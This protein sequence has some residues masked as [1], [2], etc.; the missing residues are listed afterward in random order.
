M[1]ISGLRAEV[2]E[3]GRQFAWGQWAQMGVLAASDRRDAWS[4]DPEALLLFTFEMGRD[5]P[6]L[7]DEVLD[8][9][10]VNERLVSVQRLRN[11][12]RDDADRALVGATVTSASRS[13]PRGPSRPGQG[14]VGEGRPLF[15]GTSSP[16][17]DP[18]PS[19]SEHA[20]LKPCVERSGNSQPPDL[21]LPVNFGFRL[22]HM[23]GLGARAEAVRVLLGERAPYLSAQV[24]TASAGYSKRNVLEA[25]GSLASAGVIDSF[26]VGNEQRFSAPSDRWAKLL[27][28]PSEQVPL[29]RDWP[30]L[31]WALRRT[32]RWLACP[33]HESLSS[34]MRASEARRLV[35]EIGPELSFA[36][37][38]VVDRG[39]RGADYWTDFVATVRGA[40]DRLE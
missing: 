28:M 15:R 3:R 38:R 23:L 32:A 24:V 13:R 4:S 12:T 19:F 16:I 39:S 11:L 21:A 37:V 25:L 18:D 20:L 17:L 10:L 29:H 9:M 27:A 14:N 8:W 6:R 26:L 30:A 33:E 36:G 22:R 34:Y 2:V 1:S 31:L 7:F 35:D 40:L 5:D